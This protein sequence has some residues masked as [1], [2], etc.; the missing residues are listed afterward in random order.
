[1][2]IINPN[3]SPRRTMYAWVEGEEFMLSPFAEVANTRR[4]IQRYDSRQDLERDVA[5]KGNVVQW[6]SN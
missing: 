2:K 3:R 6:L 4:P 1:M 5:A